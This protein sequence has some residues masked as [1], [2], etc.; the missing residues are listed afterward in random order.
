MNENPLDKLLLYY[1]EFT[2]T[3]KEISAYFINNAHDVITGMSAEQ[4]ARATNTS[5]A[6]ISRFCKRIGYSGF[7]DFRFDLAR[8]LVSGNDS[9]NVVDDVNPVITISNLYSQ[10]ILDIQRMLNLEELNNVAKL[11]VSSNRIKIMALNR[12]FN[13]ALQ[14][15]QRLNRMGIDSEASNDSIVFGDFISIM[16][17]DDVGIIFTTTD[18]TNS[19]GKYVKNMYE[20]KC[21]IVIFTMNPNLPFKNK[22]DY[23]IAL[24]RISK[25]T[26]MSFLDDQPIFMVF[27]E[28]LL[29]LIAKNANVKTIRTGAK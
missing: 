20:R 6:A 13:S 12:T 25:N 28:I 26:S 19:F 27:I 1:D 8:A 23:Y 4:I 17:S 21:K 3:D 16:Q 11:I 14:F 9:S 29:N 2:K 24:P 15:K 7:S 22:V 10:Y 5:K 18:N